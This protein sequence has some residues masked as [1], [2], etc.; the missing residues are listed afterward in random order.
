MG[1]AFY[2][3]PVL[4]PR[5]EGSSFVCLLVFE[6]LVF[7]QLPSHQNFLPCFC[8]PLGGIFSIQ[9][10]ILIPNLIFSR[11][12]NLPCFAFFW[13]LIKKTDSV[14]EEVRC[15]ENRYIEHSHPIFC[16]GRNLSALIISERKSDNSNNWP[17]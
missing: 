11:S 3:G 1:L 4:P 8:F 6:V 2:P 7:G 13:S 9:P 5:S 10:L 15:L 16:K 17:N 14:T 12:K